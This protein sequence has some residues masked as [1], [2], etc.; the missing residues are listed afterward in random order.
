LQGSE[1]C[2]I[3]AREA[4]FDARVFSNEATAELWLR[5]GSQAGMHDQD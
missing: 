2:E 1:Y 3:F 4:G 5:Y